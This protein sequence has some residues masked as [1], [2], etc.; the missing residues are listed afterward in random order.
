[1]DI[2]FIGFIFFIKAFSSISSSLIVN[3]KELDN[4]LLELKKAILGGKV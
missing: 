3:Y 2:S 4:N 1:M